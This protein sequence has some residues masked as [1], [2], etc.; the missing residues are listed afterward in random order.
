[1]FLILPV[2]FFTG[3]LVLIIPQA[4]VPIIII[5]IL[6]SVLIT[7]ISSTLSS[8]FKLALYHYARTGNIPEGF[9]E[10]TIGAIKNHSR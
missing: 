6:V 4:I 8:I 2:T 3:L 9:S 7:S 10:E 1:S 5:F